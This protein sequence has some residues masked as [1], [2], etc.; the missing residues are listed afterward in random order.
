MSDLY[1]AYRLIGNFQWPP[2][3]DPGVGSDTVPGVV[4]VF[5]HYHD[6]V[7]KAEAIMR[8]QKLSKPA[9]RDDL[10]QSFLKVPLP[11][12]IP[13][14]RLHEFTQDK[15]KEFLADEA[16]EKTFSLLLPKSDVAG[17]N[18]LRTNTLK[19]QGASVID[20]FFDEPGKL[21]EETFPTVPAGS[22][23]P[24]DDVYPV[25]ILRMPV[26][27]VWSRQV[28]G[29]R[30]YQYSGV[31]FAQNQGA[32]TLND[33]LR[34][35]AIL[36]DMAQPLEIVEEARVV[37]IDGVISSVPE[38]DKVGAIQN[39]VVQGK[40]LRDGGL[41]PSQRCFGRFN[42][43]KNASLDGQNNDARLP[44]SSWKIWN[45]TSLSDLLL[46][47]GFDLA[48]NRKAVDRLAENA[49]SGT[50]RIILNENDQLQ[51][52]EFSK[53]AEKITSVPHM[54]IQRQMSF[55]ARDSGTGSGDVSIKSKRLT[56]RVP[57]SSGSAVDDFY[58]PKKAV[59]T[60]EVDYQT[61]V[62][63]KALFEAFKTSSILYA[64]G[65]TLLDYRLF[66]NEDL[67]LSEQFT[68][69]GQHRPMETLEPASGQAGWFSQ[70]LFNAIVTMHRSRI[71]LLHLAPEQAASFM[72]EL[73]LAGNQTI[74][75]ML[76]RSCAA[77]R[78]QEGFL[79]WGD[80][81][82]DSKLR[83]KVKQK[84]GHPHFFATPREEDGEP[85]LFRMFLPGFSPPQYSTVHSKNHSHVHLVRYPL[86]GQRSGFA[87]FK[88]TDG[89]RLGGDNHNTPPMLGRVGSLLFKRNPGN[90]NSLLA[91]DDS[92]NNALQLSPRNALIDS[93]VDKKQVQQFNDPGYLSIWLDLQLQVDEA[94]PLADGSGENGTASDAILIP[95]KQHGENKKSPSGTYLLDVEET[96]GGPT[97][98]A[99]TLTVKLLDQQQRQGSDSF[100][101]LQRQPWSVLGFTSQSLAN[102]GDDSSN[103]VAVYDV[104]KGVWKI[105][106]RDQ[107]Y[108][109]TF[110]PMVTGESADKPGRLE[111]HDRITDEDKDNP[112]PWPNEN[113]DG[114]RRYAVE[115][116]L[117][118]PTDL[119]VDPTDLEQNFV[120]APWDSHILFS[121]TQIG[122][123]GVGFLGLR[124]EFL[125]GM[126]VS[127]D[128]TRRQA[129]A[130]VSD[131]SAL[132]GKPLGAKP[133][134]NEVDDKLANRWCKLTKA[135]NSRPERLEIWQPALGDFRAF[136]SSVFDEDVHYAFRKT[137]VLR[138]PNEDF[139]DTSEHKPEDFQSLTFSNQGLSGGALWPVEQRNLILALD[140]NPHSSDGRIEKIA[141]SPNGGDADQEARFNGNQV[142]IISKTRGGFLHF[143]K[144][145][146][147]G[148]AGVFWHRAKHVV[149]Y[150][151][152]VNATA[153]FAPKEGG[154]T[155]SRRAILRKVSEYVEI[156]EP[157]RAYPDFDNAATR[158]VGPL[159]SV[160]FNSRIIHV[161]SR[162]GE[163]LGDWGWR[164]PLWD[165]GAAVQ[166]PQV[167]EK[168][169]VSFVTSAE[170]QG[171]NAMTAQDCTNPQ[172]LYFVA[173]FKV[174]HDRTDE[175][176]P[177]PGVDYSTLPS[178]GTI[179]ARMENERE[180]VAGRYANVSRV[181]LGHSRFTWL[182]AGSGQKTNMM[183]GR[184]DKPVY[185]DLDSIT[186]S[187]SAPSP[188]SANAERG[189][190]VKAVST[191]LKKLNEPKTPSNAEFAD[192]WLPDDKG[193]TPDVL[194]RLGG[195]DAAVRDELAEDK[196]DLSTVRTAATG[197][198]VEVTRLLSQ[199]GN[200]PADE[201]AKYIADAAKRFPADELRAVSQAASILKSGGSICDKL[202][203]QTVAGLKRKQLLIL[204][205][206]E[207]GQSEIHEALNKLGPGPLTKEK[208]KSALAKELIRLATPAFEDAGG[209]VGEITR[210]IE[211][212]RAEVAIFRADLQALIT[213]YE[214]R[215]EIV[216]ALY[217][218]SKPWSSERLAQFFNQLDTVFGSIRVDVDAAIS[219][220]RRRLMAEAD[221]FSQKTSIYVTR[222]VAV[223][224]AEERTLG[225]KVQTLSGR[226][227]EAVSGARGQTAKLKKKLEEI[228]AKATDQNQKNAINEL[229]DLLE[230]VDIAIKSAEIVGNNGTETAQYIFK[231]A[232]KVEKASG[233][234]TSALK[235]FTTDLADK[236]GDEL[237]GLT[238]DIRPLTDA[239]NDGINE[240]HA[241]IKVY[242]N[243]VADFGASADEMV[244]LL[245]ARL[246][247][248]SQFIQTLEARAGS[249]IDQISGQLLASSKGLADALK[250]ENLL[251]KV[252]APTLFQPA[253]DEVLAP[254][255]NEIDLK[256]TIDSVETLIIVLSDR[257]TKLLGFGGTISEAALN[258]IG[259]ISAL[260][261]DIEGDLSEILANFDDFEKRAKAALEQLQKKI[262]DL[263]DA[264][265]LK[266][267]LEQYQAVSADVR[268]L[269]N[270]IES[271]GD[272]AE[273]Y[274]AKV[275]DQ[276]GDVTDGGFSAAPNNI[277]RL[278]SSVT[279]SPELAALKANIDRIRNRYD[280][281]TDLVETTKAN[282]LFD[283]LGDRLKAMG[284]NI[285]FDKFGSSLVPANFANLKFSQLFPNFG[286]IKLD[287]MFPSLSA[288][289]G[290]AEYVKI[291]HDFDK[292]A[293][294]AWV[295]I[296]VSVPVG[297]RAT[298]FTIG[299]FKMDFVN[300]SLTG[301]V[302]LEASKE[303][304]KVHQS[305][306][307]KILT[308]IEALV[309]GEKMVGLEEV[310]ITY[311]DEDGLDLKFDP[312]KIKLNPVMKFVQD[313]VGSLFP[314]ELGGLELI[315]RNGIPIGMEH[316]YKMPTADTNAVTSGMMNLTIM[317]RF[318]ILAYPEFIIADRFNVATKELPF[319]F[320]IFI[321]GGTGYVQV[322]A[323][324]RPFDKRL[325]VMVTAAAGGSAA[326][327]FAFGPVKGSIFVA[328]TINLSYQRVI[329]KTRDRDRGTGLTVAL[330]LVIAGN[331][332]VCGLVNIY[333][334]ILLDMLYRE[335]GAI[336]ATGVLKVRI[337]ISRFFKISVRTDVRYKLR[338]GR[339]ETTK[340]TTISTSADG[341]AKKV[342]RLD[343]ARKKLGAG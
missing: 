153:Q 123:F 332:N 271:A 252:L 138:H 272:L 298:L 281:L 231:H 108:R 269:F 98:G 238:E 63:D 90:F 193:S 130:R 4:E 118:V 134:E 289:G 41:A 125:Y 212:A 253:I 165:R 93:Y 78:T 62:T 66:W 64:A 248:A 24:S 315:K 162:W 52:P 280:A 182:L 43:N 37:V 23:P 137:A 55:K 220:M 101:R 28:G 284:L 27:P 262:T 254:L 286:G 71:D 313:T 128:A 96:L 240:V 268:A 168:P 8:W 53:R 239:Y 68:T 65:E 278:Y 172:N 22:V 177:R 305:G 329:G 143:M 311:T 158:T 19:F 256:S 291:T 302:R 13:T 58:F 109:F 17:E 104:D 340:K 131:L 204:S 105:K 185:V 140:E 190:V 170:G 189:L 112:A 287:D 301:K 184:T 288:P 85:A 156:L 176:Q 117:S 166:R 279:S 255:P 198:K 173:D 61:I 181:P 229:I 39:L 207:S 188:D 111:L 343:D 285:P 205:N 26:A 110:P 81:A 129:P 282:A 273:S 327:G 197:V 214:K 274:A 299:P 317:N 338:N 266:K 209:K 135:Y 86:D 121:Q 84:T 57:Q 147:I 234:I 237:S 323:E 133:N 51:S 12:S 83:G 7:K 230:K 40:D 243:F 276:L 226:L 290:L 227:A 242:A 307:A 236:L 211:S 148:R 337:K 21:T 330:S 95:L 258:R 270:D 5:F 283:A 195:L 136:P 119:W 20:Q 265:D 223:L 245:K 89:I 155:R 218:R 30:K 127:V 87:C 159:K 306:D 320:S 192:L 180:T 107:I 331:V 164:V 335:S 264:N 76:W 334:G 100:L 32:A 161:D 316:V 99:R 261:S 145:E 75:P 221:G 292:N 14:Q 33:N 9:D 92:T 124:G 339:S 322:D 326:L 154:E 150:A 15:L 79:R 120:T 47:G 228:K 91:G 277:L 49:H 36:P 48:G 77:R 3:P 341:L 88:L 94:T 113:K 179:D 246:L 31:E 241:T 6:G 45:R 304:K 70:A 139:S 82:L 321:L 151:R 74:Q 60:A 97:P 174:G 324:Y 217:D 336:D 69:P 244:V 259:D 202:K 308:N 263:V 267:Y 10:K 210:G 56:L 18:K 160:R 103:E 72:P 275:L 144:V 44:N 319:I 1:I 224:V 35:G 34:I 295:Q 54:R 169:Q 67:K 194:K 186:F 167:Y 25:P 293:A 122:G 203:S 250:P 73:A 225:S 149:V 312:S 42:I 59:I 157:E 222:T 296:D 11:L 325:S 187:R 294:R 178:A 251:T 233:Y 106:S 257:V 303:T 115:S 183:D 310:G 206:V 175:W 80:K 333:I 126:P 249:V 102:L 342:K 260:C 132:V 219:D 38:F 191:L 235:G 314:D 152:T 201:Y 114:L 328:L 50:N 300:S 163:D 29:G 199:I 216:S 196:P 2:F 297:Q 309:G 142:R 215:V 171:D 16:N 232:N 318:R 200:H 146:V 116:R 213:R 46:A 141:L 247:R 208:L